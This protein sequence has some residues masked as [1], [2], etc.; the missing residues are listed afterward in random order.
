MR[1][2]N[3]LTKINKIK[4]TYNIKHAKLEDAFHSKILSV[5]EQEFNRIFEKDDLPIFGAGITYSYNHNY[6]YGA[7]EFCSWVDIYLEPQFA[8]E[9]LQISDEEARS[10]GVWSEFGEVNYTQISALHKNSWSFQ[11]LKGE[12]TDIPEAEW[13]L[14]IRTFIESFI[15][16]KTLLESSGVIDDGE[17]GTI[18]LIYKDKDKALRDDI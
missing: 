4:E 15:D 7:D 13:M 6:H 9:L 16:D 10:N 2:K 11:S 12:F 5:L 17:Y 18:S 3:Y 1:R 14:N 8:I